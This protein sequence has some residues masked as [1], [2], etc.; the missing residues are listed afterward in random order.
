MRKPLYLIATEY[1][2]AIKIKIITATL[3]NVPI[4]LAVLPEK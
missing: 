1:G 3:S 4:N 2:K